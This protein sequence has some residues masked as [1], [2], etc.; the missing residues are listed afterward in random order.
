MARANAASVPRRSV[1]DRPS[2]TARPSTW[3]NTGMWVGSGVSWRNTRPGATTY[4]GGTLLHPA[5]LRAYQEHRWGDQMLELQD[6]VHP[7]GPALTE[8]QAHEVVP[9]GL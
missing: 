1:I 2:S 7:R 6:P 5:P 8:V 4:T 3:W 9:V